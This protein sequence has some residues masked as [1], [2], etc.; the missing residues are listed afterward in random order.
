MDNLHLLR[1][2]PYSR[3]RARL[4]QSSSQIIGR[5]K[6]VCRGLDVSAYPGP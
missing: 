6:V 4:L 5:A 3:N 2:H 1:W